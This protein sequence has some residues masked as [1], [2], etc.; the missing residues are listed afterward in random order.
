MSD[1]VLAQYDFL[2]WARRGVGADLTNADPLSGSLPFRGNI[3]VQ[4]A[5]QVQKRG[6]PLPAGQIT[7]SALLYGPG[8]V[9]GVDPRHILRT[10]PRHLTANFEPNYFAGIDFED[11]GLPWMFTPA[12]PSADQLRPWISL[13]ALSADEFEIPQQAPNPLPFISVKNIA[14]LPNLDE[15][16]AWA[17]TQVSGGVGGD[18][19]AQ[20]LTTNPGKFSSRLLCPRKLRPNTAYTAFLVPAFDLGVQVGLGQAVPSDPA[21]VIK[22]AWTAQTAAPLSLPVYYSFEF[23]TSD[24]GDFESLVRQL[25]PRILPAEVGLRPM[26]V[27]QPSWGVPGAGGPLGLGGALR[28][29]QTQDTPW[30][31]PGKSDFQ[32]HL[33]PLLNMTTPDTDDPRNP[34]PADPVVVPPIYGRWHAAVQKIDPAD[35]AWL[36]QMNMDPRPRSE[37]GLGT[38]VVLEERTR[39]MAAAW[40]QVA[41]IEEANQK[42]RQ[43]Q[44]ARSVLRQV[45]TQHFAQAPTETLLTITSTLHSRLLASPTTVR[46][47]LAQ[48]RLP[49]RAV[50]APFRSIAAP[51]RQLRLRQAANAQG[52]GTAAPAGILSRLNTGDISL[53]PPVHPPGGMVSIDQVSDALDPPWVPDWLRPLLPYAVWILLGLAFL[54]LILI[55]VIGAILGLLAI[56]VV[57]AIVVAGI[58]VYLAI[59]VAPFVAAWAAAAQMRFNNLTADTVSNVP[60]R[61]VFRIVPPGQ[62]L[63]QTGTGATD[64]PDAQTFRAAAI[65]ATTAL[66]APASDPAP[67]PPADLSALRV[68]IVARLDP[69]IT[70]PARFKTLVLVSSFIKPV[71]DDPIDTIMAAPEFPQPMYEP[72]R[73]LSQD[74]LLPGL[75]QIPPNTLALLVADHAFIEAY[76]VG[77]NHEMARQLLWHEYPTDQRG[78]YFRQFW[79]VRSYVPSPEE[80]QGET[81]EQI[82]EKLK[83]IPPIHT[84]KHANPLGANENRSDVVANNLVLLVRG[85]LL[86]RYPNAHIYAVEAKWDPKQG[87]VLGEKEMHTLFRGTLTPDLTFFG[88]NLTADEARGSTDRSQP[89]GWFFVFQQNPSEPRFGLEPARDPY[90]VPP[91]KEWNDLSWANFAPT[92][93]ALD[94]LGFAPASAQPQNV[95]IVVGPDNP[96]DGGNHW[97]AD[98]AQTAFITFR[99][100]VRVAIH[101]ETMLPKEA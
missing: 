60:P 29:T 84:W 67:P 48:S 37:T 62:V 41:G 89:Q 57:L 9:I 45:Y 69:S 12:A 1:P 44:L 80:L 78:S 59:R 23:T 17:H 13:I 31:D 65:A 91:V 93:A 52:A 70:V 47:T 101:A 16:W 55:I 76:M 39:L 21:T 43:A 14:A 98:A 18:P 83:D 8:D 42:L 95:S 50:S 26:A 40:Q 22:P 90:S 2:P 85:E 75:D 66:Q 15:S 30:T 27:D 56:A 11:P 51:R 71:S 100:P 19:I 79:D 73:D 94:A 88:F 3:A 74:F 10:E 32:T 34:N 87:H 86:R 28:S 6:N 5:L 54:A 33:E 38:R 20:Q 46:A 63:S 82:R 96:G 81:P 35:P 24:Q 61:P 25:Q 99:R 97:G 58:L 77:L 53:V 4:L 92:P 72:L 64:S 36:T 49:V 7:A 68:T